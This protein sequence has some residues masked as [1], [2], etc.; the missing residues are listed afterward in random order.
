MLPCTNLNLTIILAELRYWINSFHLLNFN[1]YSKLLNVL[2]R[3]FDTYNHEMSSQVT[4]Y[5]VDAPDSPSDVTY[6]KAF[7]LSNT[8][9]SIVSF[10]Q[11]PT[12]Q[13]EDSYSVVS[14]R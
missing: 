11:D 3:R 7:S 2:S 9:N 8:Y 1:I 12:V 4:V 6:S 13:Y 10:N 5:M 14:L